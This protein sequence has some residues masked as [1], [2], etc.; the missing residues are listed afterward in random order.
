MQ[1]WT[2]ILPPQGE[3]GQGA[4]SQL[5]LL[6]MEV[7]I[8]HAREANEHKKERK[9]SFQIHMVLAVGLKGELMLL[10]YSPAM[11]FVQLAQPVMA[12]GAPPHEPEEPQGPKLVTATEQDLPP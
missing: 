4:S 7:T 6:G 12:V 8:K 11:R 3:N 10:A 5:A 2:V 9:A 1:G